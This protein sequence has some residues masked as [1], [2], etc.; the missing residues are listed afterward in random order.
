MYQNTE[1][2]TINYPEL[3]SEYQ[4]I[5]IDFEEQK[6]LETL[7]EQ[8]YMSQKGLGIDYI[9]NKY[10]DKTIYQNLIIYVSENL[11]PIVQ[12]ETI[13]DND[14][15][16]QIFGKIIYSFLVIDLLTHL[17]PK[18][19]NL[20]KVKSSLD[21][22]PLHID[23]WKYHLLLA[24]SDRVKILNTIR[25]SSDNS[26]IAFE[27]FKFTYYLDLIDNDITELVESFIIPMINSYFVEIDSIIL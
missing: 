13:I 26:E 14:K 5:K 21:L 27:H 10:I 17:I 19:S 25:Q 12:L 23:E 22:R 1:R 11:V 24:V 8:Q 16:I 7:I 4:T 20:Q 15:H 3:C 18:I 2:Y 9:E 6:H